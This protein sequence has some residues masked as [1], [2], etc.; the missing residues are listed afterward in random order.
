M[1]ISICTKY[2]YICHLAVLGK[3]RLS[4]ITHS[5]MDFNPTSVILV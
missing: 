2:V 1:Y 5:P 4:I 3:C